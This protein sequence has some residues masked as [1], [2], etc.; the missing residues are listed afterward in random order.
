MLGRSFLALAP[1]LALVWL[2]GS[3]PAR[4]GSPSDDDLRDAVLL[5]NGDTLRGRVLERYGEEEVILYQGTRRK[6]IPQENVVSMR[7]V[8]D[9]LRTFL[10]E[11]IEGLTLEQEW[12][13]V[14][15]AVELQL[16][17]LAN[18]QAWRVL[19][20]NP[21]H[22][23]AHEHLGHKQRSGRYRWPLDAKQLTREEFDEA[24]RDWNDR[25]VLESEHYVVETNASVRQATEVAFDL[26]RVY[27]DWMDRFGEELHAGEDVLRSD[28]K[29]TFHVFFDRGDK[30]YKD[31]YNS[32][33]EPHYDPST[34]VSTSMGNPNLAFVYYNMGR[35]SRPVG[36]FDVAVQQLMY[37]TLVLSHQSGYVPFEVTTRSAHW[38]EL[39]FGYWLGR[40]FGGTPGYARHFE[41]TPEPQTARLANLRM[42]RGP[43]SSRFVRKE[44]TNLINLEL[45]QFYVIDKDET[46]EIYRAKA[47]SFFRFLMEVDPPVEH[48]KKVVGSGRVGLIRYLRDVYVTPTS[49]STSSFD[50]GLGGKVEELY[51]AWVKWRME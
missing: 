25:F 40:Q 48:N 47:R 1:V 28:H 50:D 29:M 23:G 3:A 38:V 32:K 31:Y 9:N 24:L 14:G 44:V 5:Q 42:T 20:L 13:L 30:G 18:V 37:S 41:F 21:E 46:S 43:L 8:R 19:E 15:L 17:A 22:E 35:G 4:G 27:L 12:S 33:R 51:D 11:H 7:T 2:P 34:P 10:A 36:L 26:E 39:G 45:R 6:K 49:H 16:P